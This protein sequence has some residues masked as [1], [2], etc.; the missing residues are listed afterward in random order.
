MTI[1]RIHAGPVVFARI[2]AASMQP[3]CAQ[4]GRPTERSQGT[5]HSAGRHPQ[6]VE[7][8]NHLVKRFYQWHLY[9]LLRGSF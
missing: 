3:H 4:S 6:P 8:G 2:L 7:R 5:G 1:N 9:S